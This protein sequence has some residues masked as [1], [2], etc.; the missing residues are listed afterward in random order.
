VLVVSQD[1]AHLYPE[2]P[3]I[4]RGRPD[5][6][7]VLDRR[8]PSAQETGHRG[9]EGLACPSRMARPEP[10]HPSEPGYPT[11]SDLS[12]PE[13]GNPIGCGRPRRGNTT[14]GA[15]AIAVRRHLVAHLQGVAGLQKRMSSRSAH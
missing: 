5:I 9:S 10:A 7:V 3:E 11:R 6:Q 14:A 1:W 12:T 4:L 2:L 15:P 13:Y 8:D